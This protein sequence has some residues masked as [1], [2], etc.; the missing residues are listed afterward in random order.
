MVQY[1]T[2]QI[3]HYRST[4]DTMSTQ[5]HLPDLFALTPFN[6]L[7][8]CHGSYTREDRSS[9]EWALSYGILPHKRD[10]LYASEPELLANISY[11]SLSTTKEHLKIIGNYL[12]LLFV[13][14][15]LTDDQDGEGAA[16]TREAFIKAL[17]PNSEDNEADTSITRMT[18]E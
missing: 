13:I 6:A 11:N 8:G 2:H 3:P 5:F 14:D 7:R 4:L 16:T 15:E 18:A 17:N 12:A 10:T 1:L 9:T